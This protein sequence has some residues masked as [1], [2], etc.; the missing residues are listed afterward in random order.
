MRIETGSRFALV[1]RGESRRWSPHPRRLLRIETGSRFALL[2][3]RGESRRWSPHPRRLLRESRRGLVTRVV[4]GS[5]GVETLVSSPASVVGWWIGVL[6]LS[7]FCGGE[8]EGV[9][10]AH[11]LNEQL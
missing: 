6:K 10:I 1:D 8:C 9:F 5:W 3:D 2:V 7:R 11:S 4:G